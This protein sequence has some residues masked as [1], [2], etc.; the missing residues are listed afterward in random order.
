MAPLY[1]TRLPGGVEMLR[2]LGTGL[3]PVSELLVTP[4]RF[5]AADLLWTELLCGPPRVL[6][7][8]AY[9]PDGAAFAALRGSTDR[10]WSANLAS[11]CPTVLV[12]GSYADYLGARPSAL[13]RK[14]RRAERFAR[15]AGDALEVRVIETSDGVERHLD[16]VTT[17]FDAAERANPRL[18][19]FA[20]RYRPFTTAMLDEAACASRLALFVLYVASKPAATALIFRSGRTLCYSG[21]RFDPD[22]RSLSPGHLVL[23][24]IVKHAFERGISEVDLLMGDTP[25]KREWSTD[26]YDTFDVTVA[27]SSW[28]YK[29]HEAAR[30]V[31]SSHRLLKWSRALR[32][33]LRGS[34][35]TR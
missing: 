1:R 8:R 17:V 34:P 33:T 27:S 23:S 6:D 9:R 18:H 20:G 15:E 16:D 25:Y 32:R 2:F 7:L 3:G 13:R 26:S 28:I 19:F 30:F 21:P 22:Y 5:D 24:A 10:D 31:A 11:A 35:T 12:E 14:L 4:G 29:L